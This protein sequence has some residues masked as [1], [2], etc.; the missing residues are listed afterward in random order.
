MIYTQ[1]IID[2]FGKKLTSFNNLDAYISH[3]D[4]TLPSGYSWKKDQFA[5]QNVVYPVDTKTGKYAYLQNKGIYPAIQYN[6]K[7][8]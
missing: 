2:F 8:L 4:N 7:I 5:D 1:P 3:P 6:G